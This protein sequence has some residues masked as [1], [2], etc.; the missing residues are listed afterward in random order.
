MRI[1]SFV[2]GA[3]SVVA[4]LGQRQ[5]LVGVSEACT[6]LP[7]MKGLDPAVLT[8]VRL[9]RGATGNA[10]DGA[11]KSAMINRN[12]LHELD[13][14]ALEKLQPDLVIVPPVRAK[15]SPCEPDPEKLR[16]LLLAMEPPPQLLE[17]GPVGL[18]D[19]FGAVRTVGEA[20]NKGAEA[21]RLVASL[22]ARVEKVR[23]IAESARTRPKVALLC[24]VAPPMLPGGLLAELVQRAGAQPLF[25]TAEGATQRV[26]WE[27]IVEAAPESILVAPC[28]FELSTAREEARQ[29]GTVSGMAATPAAAWGQVL[30]LEG[31]RLFSPIGLSTVRTLEV[32]ATLVHPHLPWPEALRDENAWAPVA[33]D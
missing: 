17:F 22:K 27:R 33:V 28:D 16:H 23:S 15:R 2:P 32:L 6:R 11:L 7:E 18:Q 10:I 19:L 13:G 21:A 3:T 12:E 29:L 8:K 30:A 1:V 4:E 25:G 20:L 14:A 9:P 24:W 5:S 26:S 31:R